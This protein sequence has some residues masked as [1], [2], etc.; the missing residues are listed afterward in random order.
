MIEHTVGDLLS[1]KLVLPENLRPKAL[2]EAHATPSAGHQGVAKTFR[3]IFENFYWP[4]Y[5]EDTAK[6]VRNCLVCQACKVEQTGPTG[7]MGQKV[8]EQPWLVVAADIVGPLPTSKNRF[9]YL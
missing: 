7:L 1:W 2:E 8:I 6:Y 9:S 3:R 5:Y 4:G